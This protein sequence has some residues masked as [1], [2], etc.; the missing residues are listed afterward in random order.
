MIGRTLSHYRIVEKL[1]EGGMGIVYKAQ[2]L[3]LDRP[4]ALKFLAE[5]LLR[6]EE[7]R[8][9]FV[10]EAKAAAALD[11]PNIC[12]VY[13]IDEA[14]GQTFIAMAYVE[15]EPLND[16]IAKGPLQIEDVIEL[17]LQVASGLGAAHEKGVVHRD[18]KPA[19]IYTTLAGTNRPRQA[20]VM[21]FGLAQ[22]V[23]SSRITKLESTIGT[24]AYMSPE[25]TQGGVVDQRTDIWALGVVL[26]EMAAG[27]LPFKG[28]YDQAILYSILNV[29]PDPLTSLRPEVPSELERIVNK[30]LAKDPETRYQNLDELA[31]D[32]RALQKARESA[33][34]AGP[35]AASKPDRRLWYAG[36]AVAV[37]AIV[38]AALSLS[39]REE[40]PA[41]QPAAVFQAVP[42]TSDPGNEFDATFSPDGTQFAYSWNGPAQDNVDVYVQV[43]G[44]G[45]PLRLTTDPGWEGR[46][47][48]SPDGRQIAF[49]RGGP[50]L[51]SIW[52]APPLGGRERM[53]IEG[54]NLN[55]SGLAWGPQGQSLV[56][57]EAESPDAGVNLVQV[58]LESGEKRRLTSPPPGMISG[59]LFPA[60]SPDGETLAFARGTNAQRE[61][62][63]LPLKGGEPRALTSRG[64]V[65]FEMAW[66]P[67]G[68]E[69][70]YSWS[71]NLG[72][73]RTLL[74]IAAAGGEPALL[75]GLPGAANPAISMQGN[76]LAYEVIS[77]DAN[78]W[79]YSLPSAKGSGPPPVKIAASNYLD[80]E[81]RLSPD[82]NRIAFAS[83]RSG[84]REIWV[85]DR[86][87]SNLLRLTSFEMACGSPRWSPDGRSIVFDSDLKG[88]W[89]VFVV[90]ADGGSPRALTSHA[91]EDSR[92]GWSRDGRWVYYGSNRGGDYQIWKVSLEGG[93]PVQ[94]TH[95]G[96]YH[97]VESPDGRFL[98]FARG[99]SQAGLWRMPAA[100]GEETAVLTELRQAGQGQWDVTDNG[101]YFVAFGA[102]PAL[103]NKWVLRLLRLDTGE[104]TTVMELPQALSGPSLEISSDGQSFLCAQFDMAGADLMLVENFR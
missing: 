21:D 37:V 25:Q 9:R 78:I 103:A 7:G 11:H 55:V 18:I 48:W 14:E 73:A 28:H 97:P 66:T 104:K 4:V 47:V 65:V 68:R 32:L 15:G 12:T 20:K 1:G 77:Y 61:I 100:G 44:S 69:L 94:V 63:L 76:R 90:G 64:G 75:A 43:V 39:R 57:G 36:A 87:G 99:A 35:V 46:A 98:Y 88:N 83:T 16:L 81:P 85:S 91:A 38:A 82:G 49:A 93:D 45:S 31:A 54:A 42:L 92:P 41:P 17:G 30:A 96:G 80:A 26:Y 58:F 10:R 59:D 8:Q 56:F 71:P 51:A 6:E 23:G 5:H 74:R 62:Y 19:N 40:A 3:K 13:E 72:A 89:D 33:S 70:V 67:D 2:D 79:R 52:L 34:A 53:V 22:L 102:D 95:G 27:S 60:V 50:A 29:Q 24:V 86:D 84:R 101:I